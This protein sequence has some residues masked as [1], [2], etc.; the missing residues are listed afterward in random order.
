[1]T[2]PKQ[3]HKVKLPKISGEKALEALKII[4]SH[5]TIAAL[6]V[7]TGSVIVQCALK[8]A[9][10]GGSQ[11]AKDINFQMGGLYNGAQGVVI[12]TAVVPILVTA[13]QTAIAFAPKAAG[14]PTPAA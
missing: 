14:V 12:A 1:M 7:M 4:A 13:G 2:K 6:A 5:P 8:P 3:Q 11:L 10:N 9:E